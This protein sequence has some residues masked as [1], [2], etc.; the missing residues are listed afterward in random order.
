MTDKPTSSR[1]DR[2]R[3]Q[4]RKN[5]IETTLRLILEK[6]YDAVTIQD[7]TDQADVGR[8]TFYIYFKDKRD[9]LWAGVN[10]TML[11]LE[12]EAHQQLDRKMPHVEYLALLNIFL[13][14]EKNR[15]LYRAVLGV[16]GSAVLAERVYDLMAKMLL[17]D[18]RSAS[19]Q[20]GSDYHIPEE[21]LAQMLS[22]L[23]IR[24]ISWWLEASGNYSA[25]EM[26]TMAYEMIYRQKPPASENK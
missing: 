15:N 2:R 3:E 14:V 19:G 5:L 10:D 16:Q 4:T 21:V 13:H 24:M 20:H 22:G 8:G 11:E 1:H 7:I 26:A 25:E 9:I 17:D 23:I 6:G 18:I 12:Q